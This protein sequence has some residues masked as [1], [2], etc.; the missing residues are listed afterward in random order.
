MQTGFFLCEIFSFKTKTWKFSAALESKLDLLLYNLSFKTE[1][2]KF[3]A[4][5]ESKLD[6]CSVFLTQN[7]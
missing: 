1:I 2:L 5:S 4:A 3:L 6:F 7:C